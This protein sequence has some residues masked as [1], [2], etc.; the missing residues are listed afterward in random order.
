[1]PRTYLGENVYVRYVEET[2]EFCTI[3]KC[4]PENFIELRPSMFSML[5]GYVHSER[6]NLYSDKLGLGGLVYA[7]LDNEEDLTLTLEKDGRVEATVCISPGV[8]CALMKY[9]D[10]ESE[11]L[12]HK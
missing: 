10:R 11:T 12:V 7:D 9:V 8:W 2:L 3:I 4:I 1:M 6:P 5:W